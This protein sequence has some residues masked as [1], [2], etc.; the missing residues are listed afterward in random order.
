MSETAVKAIHPVYVDGPMKGQDFAVDEPFIGVSAI[1]P[2]D[3]VDEHGH[4][5]V[6]T[7][8]LRKFGFL[9]GGGAF[10]LWIATSEPGEPDAEVLADLLLSDAAKAARVR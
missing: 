9:S 7:Y 4:S 2:E 8:T 5:K 3:P 6:V 10:A 1:D